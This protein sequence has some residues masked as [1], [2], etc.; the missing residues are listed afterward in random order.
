ME[1]NGLNEP[2]RELESVLRS[3]SPTSAG[4]DPIAAAFTAGRRSGARR[5][6]AWQSAA[7]VLLLL[8]I[9]IRL[10]PA[11]HGGA[12]EPTNSSTATVATEAPAPQSVEALETVI[13][14]KGVDALQ[15]TNVPAVQLFTA[16]NSSLY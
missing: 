16:S 1:P 6:H 5:L 3:L 9:G 13:R 10:M 8:V 7:A 4:I 12:I 14:E 15:A 2:E 11:R